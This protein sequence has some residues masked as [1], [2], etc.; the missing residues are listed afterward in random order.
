VRCQPWP[1]HRQTA[2]LWSG[3]GYLLFLIGRADHLGEALDLSLTH[4]RLATVIRDDFD[5]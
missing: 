1:Q 2:P 4:Q 5:L 3:V